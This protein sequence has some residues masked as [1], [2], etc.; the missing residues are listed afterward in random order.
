MKHG[1]KALLALL[2][3]LAAVLVYTGAKVFLHMDLS[4]DYRSITGIERIVLYS[5]REEQAYVRT[6]WGLTRAKKSDAFALP[7]KEEM[8]PALDALEQQIISEHPVDQA[9]FSPDGAYILYR[10]IVYNARG[11]GVTDD[12][13][14][15]YRVCRVAT[16]EITTIYGG[17]REWFDI[18]WP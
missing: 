14:C 13:Y 3:V 18:G 17:Y 15:Y 10:E 1:K 8:R 4:Q 11:S 5:S 6:W 7:G 16:G 12:E 9:V 2:I